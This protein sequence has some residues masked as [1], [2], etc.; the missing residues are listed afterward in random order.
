MNPTRVSFSDLV[1]L[2][3]ERVGG[4]AV[5]AN[6]DFFAPKENLVKASAPVFIADKYTEVGKWMDGW[7]S[8]RKRGAALGPDWCVLRLGIP[9][10]L[11]GVDVDTAHFLGNYPEYASLDAAAGAPDAR[12]DSLDWK[13]ILPK[14]AL[15]GGTQNLF[16]ISDPNRWTHVRLNIFPDGGVARL[17]AY[18]HAKPDWKQLK[19]SGA[20]DV[21]AVETGGKAI[22]CS[23]QF[24]SHP[25]NLLMPGRAKT[26]GEG[27]ETKR[28]R[29][30]G[31]DWV[32]VRLGASAKIKK[33]DVDTHHYKGNFPESCSIEACQ[34]GGGELLPCEFRD[35]KDIKWE[36]I[37]P[38]TPLKA[39]HKH[40]FESELK[41]SG[42]F[43]HVRLNIFP[44]GG[45]SRLRVY[46]EPV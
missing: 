23:D 12:P 38:R 20:V 37:L 19:A 26:M 27:W 25:M 8:R 7:E 30:P 14:S 35:R 2:V 4:Q 39:D 10:V 3:S 36:E 31:S 1:D 40:G 32:V 34:L 16:S 24:F 41:K 11:L 33:I 9:G 18:G 5:A 43:D 44:D 15:H 45:V 13:P 46:G 6:D 21:A 28:R 29:G 22:A 17:R 42:P